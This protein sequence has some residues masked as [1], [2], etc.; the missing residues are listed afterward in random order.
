[1]AAVDLPGAGELHQQMLPTPA[2][3]PD[4]SGL[5]AP[6][7]EALI[8]PAPAP[9]VPLLR[10]SPLSE[11]PPAQ[12][13]LAVQDTSET[14]AEEAPASYTPEPSAEAAPAPRD[15]LDTLP[16]QGS[17]RA[18][19]A[20]TTQADS[21]PGIAAQPR[22]EVVTTT[23]TPSPVLVQ[24]APADIPST[25]AANLQPPAQPFRLVSEEP[26]IPLPMQPV[27]PVGDA[28]SQ[29]QANA[30]G[31]DYPVIPS[32]PAPAQA[33]DDSALAEQLPGLQKKRTLQLSVGTLVL[34]FSTTV[35]AVIVI[36][37]VMMRSQSPSSKEAPA[38]TRASAPESLSPG[39]EQP[40]EVSNTGNT[41]ANAVQSDSGVAVPLGAKP[42]PHKRAAKDPGKLPG[43][44]TASE[45]EP[46]DSKAGQP[47]NKHYIPNEL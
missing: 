40:V 23:P 39:A 4:I 1:M 9:E 10:K 8:Q 47:P 15:K 7:E 29:A 37:L 24:P 18:V 6:S 44:P 11:P 3:A 19:A 14:S 25:P 2:A 42:D 46:G 43:K 32:R 45:A 16:G 30:G 27:Q 38:P 41:V 33:G 20:D 31:Q 26:F 34:G 21:H 35:L 12:P 36:M 28:P 22:P 17:V 5:G 13:A